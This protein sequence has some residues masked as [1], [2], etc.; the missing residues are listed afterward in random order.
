LG[1]ICSI[2][3]ETAGLMLLT[4]PYLLDGIVMVAETLVLIC[5]AHRLLAFVSPSFVSRGLRLSDCLMRFV[6]M[7]IV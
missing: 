7:G 6:L 3:G 2:D 5:L 1:L 4:R